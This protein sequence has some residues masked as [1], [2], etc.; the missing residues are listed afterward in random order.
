MTLDTDSLLNR[1]IIHLICWLE[2]SL[3]LITLALSVLRTEELGWSNRDA[4]QLALV[5]CLI[6]LAI[7]SSK[8][9]IKY[10]AISLFSVNIL[11]FLA[12]FLTLGP[13]AGSVYFLPIAIFILALFSSPRVFL[14]VLATVPCSIAFIAYLFIDGKLSYQVNV[15][16]LLY[17]YKHWLVYGFCLTLCVWITGYTLISYRE[18]L[19]LSLLK[20]Q[21]QKKQL[22]HQAEHD[23]LTNMMNFRAFRSRMCTP[24]SPV[25]LLF[26]DLDGF[27]QLNDSKGH[28]IGDECLKAVANVIHT[29]C[30]ETGWSC[31]LGGDEFLVAVCQTTLEKSIYTAE[32]IILKIKSLNSLSGDNFN[33]SA[34]IG[35]AFTTNPD[36]RLEVLKK[37]ADQAM[38]DAKAAGK[39]QCKTT[40]LN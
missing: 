23:E 4:I 26:I 30:K 33:V 32:N 27:K 8:L 7:S 37:A 13:L 3:S 2:A 15:D 35:I 40:F 19:R 36:T 38:Y 10:C 21:Q 17:S 9:S 6:T 20:L 24:S 25:S 1:K 12:G 34:S 31:R 16:A 29:Q 5:L 18:R 14:Y 28:D 39:G 11:I 22:M